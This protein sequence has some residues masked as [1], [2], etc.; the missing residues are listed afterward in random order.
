MVLL[1]LTEGL[2]KR[3]ILVGAMIGIMTIGGIVR[4]RVRARSRRRLQAALQAYNEIELTRNL[5]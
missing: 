5:A 1:G 4:Q 3:M 2:D